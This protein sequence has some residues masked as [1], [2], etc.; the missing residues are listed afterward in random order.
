MT[1]KE[2]KRRPYAQVNFSP[3]EELMAR[4][5]AAACRSGLT[6]A[7]LARMIV[8]ENLGRYERRPRGAKP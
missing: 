5:R 6:T 2:G 3:G 4:L 8:A 1:A 7:M